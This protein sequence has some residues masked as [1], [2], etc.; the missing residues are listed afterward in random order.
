MMMMD[1]KT[2]QRWQSRLHSYAQELWNSYIRDVL[3]RNEVT[4]RMRRVFGF[5]GVVV[6]VNI[7]GV[8]FQLQKHD[9]RGKIAIPPIFI[10]FEIG[11]ADL[12]GD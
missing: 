3:T 8:K 7:R 11:D 12:G 2:Y 4:D 1:E 10:P 5:D 9:K 6:T